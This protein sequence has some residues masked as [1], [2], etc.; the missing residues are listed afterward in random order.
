MSEK[1]H[2][3]LSQVRTLLLE[4]VWRPRAK[5]AISVS[6]DAAPAAVKVAQS[7]LVMLVSRLTISV[8]RKSLRTGMTLP[9]STKGVPFQRMQAGKLRVR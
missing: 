6:V 8:A 1:G 7:S 9:K 3:A 4:F 5:F 2:E